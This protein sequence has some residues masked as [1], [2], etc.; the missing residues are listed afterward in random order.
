MES[1][2]S[3][4]LYLYVNRENHD[5]VRL[6]E[7]QVKKHNDKIGTA[8]YPD[9]GFDLFVPEQAVFE[10]RF[11]SVFINH[12]I[13]CEMFALNSKLEAQTTGFVVHPRS[14]LSKTP[15]MLANHTGIIDAGYRGWITGAFRSFETNYQVDRHARLLQ[16]CHPSLCPVYV[17]LVDEEQFESTE[18]GQGG[19]GSTGV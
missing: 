10:N 13:K 15:L 7:S 12:E 3:A 2:S 17:Q 8:V 11:E 6:Y 18:R 1:P 16:I 19:F 5:L 14:S 4:V 9:S